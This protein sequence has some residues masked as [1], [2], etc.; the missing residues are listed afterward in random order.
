[1]EF[2]IMVAFDVV[3]AVGHLSSAVV[4]VAADRIVAG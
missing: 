4:A 1:M 3:A 2:A